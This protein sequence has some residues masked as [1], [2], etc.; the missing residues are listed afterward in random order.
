MSPPRVL[1]AARFYIWHHVFWSLL[2][3]LIPKWYLIFIF[4]WIWFPQ[5]LE[6]SQK[7]RFKKTR[8]FYTPPKKKLPKTK[9]GGNAS[10]IQAAQV[11]VSGPV[12]GFK[13]CK[14]T[15][16]EP[17]NL[18][19][20]RKVGPQCRNGVE[21]INLWGFPKI[22]VPQ[23]GWFIWKN[24]IKMDDLGVP[25]FKETS[26]WS[27]A[28]DGA[29]LLLTSWALVVYPSILANLLYFTNLHFHE[30]RGFLPFWGEVLWRHNFFTWSFIHPD[31]AGFLNHQDQQYVGLY[32]ENLRL[33]N[34]TLTR[35]DAA[36]KNDEAPK[37]P[38]LPGKVLMTTCSSN[39][40]D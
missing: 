16:M 35:N 20:K 24:P 19:E 23:N 8:N 18:K 14:L 40:H 28:I 2:L 9:E 39:S 27:C 21:S 31:G 25:P 33:L 32:H 7:Q 10:R 1:I 38:L 34:A 26:V 6:A 15:N 37:R 13:K 29:E 4:L 30:I 5:P 3:P 17:R 12:F 36:W 22:G 11:F